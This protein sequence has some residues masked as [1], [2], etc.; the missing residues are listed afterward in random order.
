MAERLCQVDGSI[1][2]HDE[3]A[4]GEQGLQRGGAL[5]AAVRRAVILAFQPGVEA[6]V[7]I[8]D[9]GQLVG[10]QRGQKLLADGFFYGREF[11][12]DEDLNAQALRW[13][14]GTANVRRHGAA[15]LTDAAVAARGAGG[16]AFAPA[17]TRRWRD[18][19]FQPSIKREPIDSVRHLPRPYSHPRRPPIPPLRTR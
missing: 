17:T 18:F 3:M 12:N 10:V 2:R 1:D 14:E 19:S 7:E 5:Q 16:E 9:A 11:V 15:A 8:G 4:L 13:L 6:L